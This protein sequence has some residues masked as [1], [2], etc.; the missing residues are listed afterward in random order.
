[1]K[2]LHPRDKFL[3][4]PT[5][6]NEVMITQR[7]VAKIFGFTFVIVGLLGFIP[8][9]LVG[10]NGIFQ[11]NLLHDI[12][13]LLSGAV[14][15][16]VGFSSSD[17]YA[18]YYHIGFGAVYALVTILGFMGVPWFVN[19]LVINMADN[20]LHLLLTAGLLTAGFAIPVHEHHTTR[21]TRR[22]V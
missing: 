16:A 19:L 9:G 1:M 14:G 2:G 15:L 12:I 7:L 18:K 8:L 22:T 4:V 10:E 5:P 6:V 17:L 11:T 13:H 20:V 3:I 21:T